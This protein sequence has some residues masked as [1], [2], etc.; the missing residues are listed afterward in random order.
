MA[1]DGIVLQP[2]NQMQQAQAAAM[3][4]QEKLPSYSERYYDDFFEYRCVFLASDQRA[5]CSCQQGAAAHTRRSCRH[6]SLTMDQ[7]QRLPKPMRLLTEVRARKSSCAR[8][9]RQQSWS[10]APRALATSRSQSCIPD[11][12]GTNMYV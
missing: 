9:T 12:S 2:V 5:C 7:A 11:R 6:V 10:L 4:Q 8:A 3:D 1:D